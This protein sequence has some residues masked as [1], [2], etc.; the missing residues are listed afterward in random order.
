LKKID[1]IVTKAT[2]SWYEVLTPAGEVISCRIK[3]KFRLAES[4]A[5]NPVVIG[6]R[7]RFHHDPDVEYAVI[8]LIRERK[9]TLVRKATNLSSRYHIIAANLDL[10]VIMLSLKE[11]SVPSGFIDRML[12]IAEAY[13]IK[14]C[15]LFNKTDLYKG[16]DIEKHRFLC[17][18]YEQIGYKVFSISVKTTEGIDEFFRYL[19][20]KESLLVGQSGV[21]KSSL[22]NKLNQNLG[23]RVQAVSGYSDRGR[24]TT[25]H[26]MMYAFSNNTYII[27]SPGIRDLGLFN[28]QAFELSHFMPDMAPFTANC[29]FS[30]CLH[31]EEP[32]CGVL[33]AL[34]KGLIHP[35][36]YQSYLKILSDF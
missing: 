18:M 32:G 10:A 25:S 15:V 22:L 3:G 7:V 1:G 28:I 24:H 34:E 27:D 9:N 23:I 35:R 29:R 17:E 26:Y 36:R 33:E 16:I 21:G 19:H 8:D 6:D 12:L 31:V 14:P 5:T 4:G 2:G 20:G 13:D 11:P 30:T